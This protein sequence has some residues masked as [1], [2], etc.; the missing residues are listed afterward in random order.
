MILIADSGSTKTDWRMINSAGEISQAKSAGYNPYYQKTGDLKSDI[1]NTLLSKIET[2]VNEIFYYGAGCGSEQNRKLI[3]NTLLDIFPSSKIEVS[4]DLLAAARALCG[5]EPG[6]ACILGTG[7]NSCS[8]DGIEILENIP[9]LGYVM[10]DEG[11]G[12]Y[13]GK[14]LL[15]DFLRGD[16]PVS[17]A[18]KMQNRFELS[19]DQVLEAVYQKEKPSKYLAGF[20]R[21]I[22]QNIKNPYCYRLVYNVL[23]LFFETNILKYENAKSSKIHFTGSVAFYYSNILRQV[24][25]DM[26]VS[27]GNIVESPIAGLTL[28]H[29]KQLNNS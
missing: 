23:K 29:Q 14:K 28:Y 15:A 21:F 17:I 7:S 1:E 24:A 20:S 6:I 13:L 10:G 2:E 18:E 22:F 3:S 11:S 26:G 19:K 9:S 25:N 27:V 16:M 5:N 12:A 8:Y 4:H